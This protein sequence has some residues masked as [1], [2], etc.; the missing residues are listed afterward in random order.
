MARASRDHAYEVVLAPAA[1]RAIAAIAKSRWGELADALRTELA[2]G[3]NIANEVR[4]DPS[5]WADADPGAPDDMAYRATPLSVDGYTA[6]HR[7]LSKAEIELLAEQRLR[8]RRR[9]LTA[10]SGFYV[11]D[12]LPAESAFRRWPRPV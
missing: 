8:E 11:I 7:P 2:N 10:T 1:R 9:R 3:P 5:I 12:L 6:I 4:I